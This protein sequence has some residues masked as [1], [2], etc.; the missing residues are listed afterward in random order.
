MKYYPVQPTASTGFSDHFVK[1][2]GL[3][4]AHRVGNT[5]FVF[6]SVWKIS[7]I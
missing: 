7:N 4:C 6:V 2:C 1:T 5:F 3:K